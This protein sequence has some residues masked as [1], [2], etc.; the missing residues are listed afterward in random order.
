[1]AKHLAALQR[2]D[3]NEKIT[4]ETH[5]E[6]LHQLQITMLLALRERGRLNAMQHRHAEEKLNHQRLIRARRILE[7]EEPS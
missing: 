4:E 7:R 3:H 6:F 1:M 5:Y 2:I